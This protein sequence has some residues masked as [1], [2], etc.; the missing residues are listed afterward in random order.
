MALCFLSAEEREARARSRAIDRNLRR[1]K[2]LV[3]NSI[4]IL[5]LGAGESGKSTVLKQMRILHG[6]GYSASDKQ[7]FRPVMYHNIL[8]VP[9]PCPLEPGA[10]TLSILSVCRE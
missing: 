7:D 2:Q 9:V 5:L 10:W 4:K 1:E 3:Q 8:K 6:G